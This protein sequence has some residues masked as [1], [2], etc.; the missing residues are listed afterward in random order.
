VEN[1]KINVLIPVDFTEISENGL[2]TAV[3]LAKRLEGTFHLVHIISGAV[4]P[5]T[6]DGPDLM[7][8]QQPM[9]ENQIVMDSLHEKREND[10]K[11][12]TRKYDFGKSDTRTEVILGDFNMEISKYVND[13][14]IDMV[15]MG[16][17]GEDSL[18]EIFSGS[19]A[20]RVIRHTDIPVLAIRE[21]NPDFRFDKMMIALD[22]RDHHEHAV[23]RIRNFAQKMD[24]EVILV[25]VIRKKEAIFGNME[26]KLAE[27]ADKYD[28]RNY[29]IEITAGGKVAVK[30]EEL[31]EKYQV[32]IIATLSEAESGLIRLFFG[33]K[34]KDLLKHTDIPLL[35]VHD[36]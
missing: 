14:A 20:E 3:K 11:D 18:T 4:P 31:S 34:T 30:L 10:L 16:T 1:N 33:S 29:R 19:H 17:E 6:M 27:F 26:E 23:R 25:H 24:M 7:T 12:L 2:K 32:D 36:R 5:Y 13:H 28:F 22:I 8:R 35:S 21:Y 9:A 15:V